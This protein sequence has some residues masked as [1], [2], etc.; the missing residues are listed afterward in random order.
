MSNN[1]KKRMSKIFKNVYQKGKS[2]GNV[3]FGNKPLSYEY[4]Y[5]LRFLT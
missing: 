2:P 5:L 4:W 1:G 3:K